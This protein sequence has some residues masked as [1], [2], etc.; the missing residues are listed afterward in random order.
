MKISYFSE[1]HVQSFSK[2]F[3]FYLQ[4]TARVEPLLNTPW[5]QAWSQLPTPPGC[6]CCKLLSLVPF[7][8]L[9]SG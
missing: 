9:L 4:D 7:G 8:S 3:Q 2:I 5:P 1:R 6:T